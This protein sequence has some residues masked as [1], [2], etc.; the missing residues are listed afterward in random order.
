[1][2]GERKGA[3]MK[4]RG[5][6]PLSVKLHSGDQLPVKHK[7]VDPVN[8]DHLFYAK[9]SASAKEVFVEATDK[10]GRVYTRRA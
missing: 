4:G 5:M 7:W 9:V 2:D 3:M 6:D 10:W 8:T 1:E